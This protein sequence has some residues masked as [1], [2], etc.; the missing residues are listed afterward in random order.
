MEDFIIRQA[1]FED[2]TFV[3]QLNYELFEQEYHLFNKNLDVNWPFSDWGEKYFINMINA[4]TV[5][6]AENNGKILGYLAGSVKIKRSYMCEAFSEIENML[7]AEE[8]RQH[9]IGS[10]LVERFKEL[11]K[12]EGTGII[13]VTVY[14]DNNRAIG[15]Y[16][17]MG[18]LPSRFIYE[19]RI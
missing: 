7:V 8:Y 14:A 4:Q 12:N 6:V 16:K 18:L 3:R 9:G 2:L 11:A 19:A 10:R 17:K 15:F 1:V 5:L 13:R